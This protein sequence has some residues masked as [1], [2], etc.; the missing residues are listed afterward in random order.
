MRFIRPTMA[1]LTFYCSLEMNSFFITKLRDEPWM[2]PGI[3]ARFDCVL[4]TCFRHTCAYS[5]TA[6]ASSVQGGKVPVNDQS[7]SSLERIVLFSTQWR[8]GFS[9]FQSCFNMSEENERNHL[10]KTMAASAILGDF[11]ISVKHCAQQQQWFISST[12]EAKSCLWLY[13]VKLW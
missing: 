2:P 1:H 9:F 10:K 6:M 11:S 12:I 3:S 5:Q 8:R 13:L 7:K 4:L